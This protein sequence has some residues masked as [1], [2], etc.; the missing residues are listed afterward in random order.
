VDIYDGETLLAT[1]E[2][3]QFRK[4]LRDAGIG[5][6]QHGFEYAIPEALRDGKEHTIRVLFSG[7]D[8]DLIGSPMTVTLKEVRWWSPPNS[9]GSPAADQ[10]IPYEEVVKRIHEVVPDQ[11]PPGAIVL[12]VG[13][14]HVDLLKFE[15]R[16]SWAF[17]QDKDGAYAD[18]PDPDEPAEAK[19][20]LERLRV[21]GA[22]FLLFPEPTFWWLDEKEG[23]PKFKQHLDAQYTR[24]YADRYCII[25]RLSAPGEKKP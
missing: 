5:S 23:Y 3:K 9:R 19:D 15:G 14:R 13:N 25:Y 7:T 20:H 16:T 6:G 1:V 10:E 24:V 2:A 8:V 4:D 11:L 12:V 18:D 22:Q 17:P 21:K